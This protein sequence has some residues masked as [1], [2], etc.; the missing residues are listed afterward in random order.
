VSCTACRASL[1]EISEASRERARFREMAAEGLIDLEELRP[2]LLQ[3][4][5]NAIGQELQAS[6]RQPAGELRRSCARSDFDALG[7]EERHR[8]Y[9]IIGLA[10]YLAPDGS[11]EISGDV[12]SFSR[13][14]MSSA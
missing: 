10:V 1:E 12:M 7:S 2:Q 4:T 5:R 13:P 6:Q 11:F 14:K 3:D 9:R 8:A